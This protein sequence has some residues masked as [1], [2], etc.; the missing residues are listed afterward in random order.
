MMDLGPTVQLVGWRY[1][2]EKM[3]ITLKAD[4]TTVVSLAD[5]YAG[6]NQAGVTTVPTRSVTVLG[7]RTVVMDTVE[8]R[9]ESAVTVGADK[10]ARVSTG[11]PV[12]GN[13][14]AGG[15]PTAGWVGGAVLAGSMFVLAGAYVLR[16][17]GGEP[18]V[19]DS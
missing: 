9:G 19:A 11:A 1:N 7:T 17:E 16:K 4:T 8:L 12:V 6:M 10:V 13:P 2:G 18:K 5:A 14:F 3:F 15:S